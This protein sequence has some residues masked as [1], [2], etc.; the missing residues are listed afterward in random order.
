MN[1]WQMLHRIIALYEQG[2]E[3]G[4]A[5]GLAIVDIEAPGKSAPFAD[6]IQRLYLDSEHKWPSVAVH[7]NRIGCSWGEIRRLADDLVSAYRRSA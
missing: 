1:Q 7:Y 3:V 2:G 6:I 5:V 4:A